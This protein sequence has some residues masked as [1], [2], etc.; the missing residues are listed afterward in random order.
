MTINSNSPYLKNEDRLGDV[1]AA[2]QV[3]GSYPFYKLSYENW[4]HRISGEGQIEKNGQYWKLIF[5][6]HPEFFRLDTTGDK[7][8]LVWRR[9]YKRIYNV[10][11]QRDLSDEELSSLDLEGKKRVS[12]SP[13]KG[14]EISILINTAVNLH[15]RAIEQDKEHRWMSSPLFAL[16]NIALGGF[17]VWLG[18]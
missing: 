17:L 2:I 6:A 13:L 4:A 8:S 5:E 3:M 9:S 7:A 12:R 14:D 10:D 1:I 16:L 15:A 18:K 11:K